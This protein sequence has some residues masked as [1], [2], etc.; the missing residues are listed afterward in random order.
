VEAELVAGRDAAMR[1]QPRVLEAWLARNAGHLLEPYAHY[2]LLMASLP[3]AD[4]GEVRTFLLKN[5]GTPLAESLR[6]E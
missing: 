5:E 4:A 2:W 6:R 1:G 3:R